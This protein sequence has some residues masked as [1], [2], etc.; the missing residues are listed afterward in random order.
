MRTRSRV[1]GLEGGFVRAVV[2]EIGDGGDIAGLCKDLP[3]GAAF[4][5]AGAEFEAGLKFEKR[6][7]FE[8]SNL[9]KK[10]T[11]SHLN[12]PGA[13]GRMT[14]PVQDSGVGLV[15][16][17]SAEGVAA[18][19]GADLI[20]A[21]TRGGR[22]TVQLA[23]AIGK[24]VFSAVQAPDFDGLIKREH[25]CN[26]CGGPAGDDSEVCAAVSLDA[27]EL[28]TNASPGARLKAIDA[29]AGEGAIVVE[30]QQRAMLGVSQLLKEAIEFC[31]SLARDVLWGTPHCVL[32]SRGMCEDRGHE[33][34]PA[35]VAFRR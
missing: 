13:S 2:A 6:D 3:D 7:A 21:G 14:A 35:C 34:R 19:V 12:L 16:V 27:L 26:F 20:K 9:L 1:N 23:T 5:T 11:G 30:E 33:T 17:E 18:E 24:K 25:G 22:R 4:I 32:S 10:G 8:M 29:E 15:L 31:G 28:L